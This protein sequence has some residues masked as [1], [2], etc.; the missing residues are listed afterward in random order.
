MIRIQYEGNRGERRPSRNDIP[1]RFDGASYAQYLASI[2]SDAS[3]ASRVFSSMTTP[4]P[5]EVAAPRVSQSQKHLSKAGLAA[6][7]NAIARAL[8]ETGPTRV[9]VIA[10]L[11][12]MT[13]DKALKD[14]IV[15][16]AQGRVEMSGKRNG[17]KWSA[18]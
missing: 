4:A 15:L 14:L 7:R 1:V 3:I 12:G 11:F 8:K 6:R 9:S 13:R 18:L 10:D 17:T 16:K 5:E 2:H